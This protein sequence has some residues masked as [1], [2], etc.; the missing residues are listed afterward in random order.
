[1]DNINLGFDGKVRLELTRDEF[2]AFMALVVD[3]LDNPGT[4]FVAKHLGNLGTRAVIGQV[5]GYREAAESLVGEIVEEVGPDGLDLDAIAA[6]GLPAPADPDPLS[7]EVV[8]KAIE[9]GLDDLI[10]KLTADEGGEE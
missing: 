9:D 1:M 4:A 3:A 6:C 2:N 5:P 8:E 10:D 7:P